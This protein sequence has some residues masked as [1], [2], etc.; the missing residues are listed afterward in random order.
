MVR[1]LNRSRS[2]NG[3]G[4][5]QV[6]AHGREGSR[7]FSPSTSLCRPMWSGEQQSRSSFWRQTRVVLHQPLSLTF[8]RKNAKK[9]QKLNGIPVCLS[10]KMENAPTWRPPN[11]L[12]RGAF[13]AIFWPFLLHIFNLS[14]PST[15]TKQ[16]ENNNK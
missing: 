15:Y 2:M 9:R 7:V 12:F 6:G 14:S 10:Q 1:I 11:P 4:R 8:F 3:N 5:I 16:I 13:L